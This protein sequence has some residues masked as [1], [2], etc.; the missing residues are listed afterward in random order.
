MSSDVALTTLNWVQ[1]LPAIQIAV[2]LAAA[3]FCSL[4]P[5]RKAPWLL[6]QLVA[7][8]SLCVA[9][10]I[11]FQ[12]LEHGSITY[13]L[14]GWDAPWGISIDIDSLNTLV[15]LLV[16][17]TTT[18]I[19]FAAKASL[20]Q[21][22]PEH[23]AALYN[24]ALIL[25]LAASIG[26]TITGDAFNVFVFL[27]ISSLSTYALIAMG[28][29]PRALLAS[30]RY[31]IMGTIGATFI[32]IAI[33]LM[34]MATGTLNMADLSQR[35]PALADSSMIQ[36]SFAFFVIG[37]GLKIALFPMH[38]WLPSAYTYAPSIAS[39]V[40]AATAT[41]VSMYVLIRFIFDVYG[42]DIAFDTLNI[43]L[44]LLPLSL[45][46]IVSGSLSAIFRTELKSLLAYSSVA[47]MG[48]MTIGIATATTAGFTAATVHM[49][50]HGIIKA[51]LFLVLVG[52]TYRLGSCELKQL[53]G[54]GRRMPWTIGAFVAGGLS[55]M[56][57]PTT[58]GF[59]SKWY[60]ILAVIERGWWPVV[61][62]ILI[63]S[64][65]AVVY[66]WKVVEHAWFKEAD[67]TLADKQTEAPLSILI[68]VWIMVI[69]NFYFGLDT[70]IPVGLAE[71]AAQNLAGVFNNPTLE[72]LA[73]DL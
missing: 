50:N 13:R 29:D 39:T 70:S 6:S 7:L 44:F 16:T 59:I 23:K 64:L 2:P 19:T 68:P 43:A 34:Y 40:L 30:F 10:L 46:A 54:A 73:G 3:P 47:Q 37:A 11:Y 35:L 65:L 53:A 27:E 48:Y 21:E 20:S 18:I 4:L 22:I 25:G 1:Q 8:T 57:V 49:F 71:T 33:G 67:Q 61:I 28:K 52:I 60:L 55:L 38:F 31:L 36:A 41:K 15:L 72:T 24:T 62:L 5:G 45:I 17:F 26:I 14:G 56:G 12:V 42:V 32:L 63:S 69:A 51:A 9:F 58:A 66:V